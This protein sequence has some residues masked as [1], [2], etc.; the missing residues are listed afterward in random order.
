MIPVYWDHVGSCGIIFEFFVKLMVKKRVITQV[1]YTSKPSG[2]I[3]VAMDADGDGG[4]DPGIILLN[5]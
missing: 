4:N 1:Y 3:F 2:L 5:G